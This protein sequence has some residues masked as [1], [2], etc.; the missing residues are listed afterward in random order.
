MPKLL[1]RQNQPC[2]LLVL[3]EAPPAAVPRGRPTTAAPFGISFRVD[4]VLDVDIDLQR[5]LVDGSSTEITPHTARSRR[6]LGP[7][8]PPAA[9]RG[10]R[11]SHDVRDVGK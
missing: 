2:V 5:L 11:I 10:W 4:L 7:G 9:P 8:A 1:D 3:N 6:T